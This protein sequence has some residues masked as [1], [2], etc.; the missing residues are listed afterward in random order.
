MTV[1]GFD[2]QNYGLDQ[3]YMANVSRLVRP[4]FDASRLSVRVSVNVSCTSFFG[5]SRNGCHSL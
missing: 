2:G 4:Y 1:S 3:T 5:Q